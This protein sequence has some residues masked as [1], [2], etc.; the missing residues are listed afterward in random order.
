MAVAFGVK[1]GTGRTYC[2]LCFQTIIEGEP[3]IYV[4]G[5]GVSGQVHALPEHCQYLTK[6]LLEMEVIE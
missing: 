1:M 4:A 5:Y 3:A 2:R 6:R